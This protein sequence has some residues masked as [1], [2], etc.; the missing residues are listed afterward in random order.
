MHIGMAW[1]APREADETSML[2]R[3][4]IG[5]L[6]GGTSARLF[7]EVRQ[8]RSLCYS[9]NASYS[10]GRDTGAVMLYAGTTPQR[11]QETLDVCATEVQRLQEGVTSDEFARAT[12]GL[13]SRLVMQGES[14]LAR[15]AAISSDHFRIG[16]ARTLDER[17]RII[18]A[19]THD[20]LNDYLRRRE[21]GTCTVASIGSV[22][23]AVPAA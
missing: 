12:T 9:V 20:Q 17:A 2:E 3:L 23:P 7:T 13:K 4:A 21:F 8:K 16:R 18:D 10:A 15:A 5:V 19:I 14:T 6:S 1:E 11:A 22:E